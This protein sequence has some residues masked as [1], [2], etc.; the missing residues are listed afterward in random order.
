MTLWSS[1]DDSKTFKSYKSAALLLEIDAIPLV[2]FS[3]INFALSA[4]SSVSTVLGAFSA[5][6]IHMDLEFDDLK[7]YQNFEQVVQGACIDFKQLGIYKKA[8]ISA[9]LRQEEISVMLW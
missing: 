1:I 2:L 7:Q 9:A 3:L 5:Y 6:F 4:V 8:D